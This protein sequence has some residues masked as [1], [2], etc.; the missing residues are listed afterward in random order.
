MECEGEERIGRR[1]EQVRVNELVDVVSL[2]DDV[3]FE[4]VDLTDFFSM[5]SHRTVLQ[6]R[7]NSVN[8]KEKTI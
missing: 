6:Y 1:E 8:V 7:R 2:E 3:V 5:M 4:V